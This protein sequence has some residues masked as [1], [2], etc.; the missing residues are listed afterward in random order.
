MTDGRESLHAGGNLYHVCVAE[1]EYRNRKL[2]RL[3]RRIEEH[4]RS[5]ALPPADGALAAPSS[6]SSDLSELL[7]T[8][9]CSGPSDSVMTK[10]TH[11]T[12]TQ[13]FTFTRVRSLQRRSQM[14]LAFVSKCVCHK[15]DT[16][17][18]TSTRPLGH[19]SESDGQLQ[20]Q[21][22]LE[23]LTQQVEE[24]SGGVDQLTADIKQLSVNYAQV[25]QHN[26]TPQAHWCCPLG[27]QSGNWLC[28]GAGVG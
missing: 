7:Q 24:L 21:E 4:L 20:Q 28:S 13:K 5:A 25:T 10:G 22:V 8:F 17:P 27:G 6:S 26:T 18:L 16:A 1:Q 19:K 15:Q 14:Q 2:T 3:R 11:F 23:S 12:H 9:R